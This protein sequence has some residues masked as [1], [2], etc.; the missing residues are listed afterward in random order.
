M[1]RKHWQS[2]TVWHSSFVKQASLVKERLV[3][4]RQG[5]SLLARKSRASLAS[6]Y[7]KMT[8]CNAKKLRSWG[9]RR[10][11]N[12]CCYFRGS[13]SEAI[14]ALLLLW[15]Y[16]LW[17]FSDFSLMFLWFFS[18]VSVMLLFFCYWGYRLKVADT[19]PESPDQNHQIKELPAVPLMCHQAMCYQLPSKLVRRTLGISLP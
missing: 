9:G 13:T 4:E 3:K 15:C 17:C 6:I 14:W 19:S 5:G 16:C 8:P 7:C 18:D 2:D 10:Q 11:A 1:S 12:C